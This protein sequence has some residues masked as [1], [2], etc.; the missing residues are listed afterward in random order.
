MKSIPSSFE[1]NGDQLKLARSAAGFSLADI[2]REIGVTRQYASRLESGATPST[3]QTKML[4]KLLSV[5]ESFFYGVRSNVLT[6]EQCHF[7]S[8]RSATKTLK[9]SITSQV[10]VLNS[11]II[12][13]LEEWIEFPDINIPD[14]EPDIEPFLSVEAVADE[15]RKIWNLGY[16]P[17][18]NMTKLLES[19]G[20]IV[21]NLADADERIDAF[22]VYTHR[23]LVVRNTHKLSPCRLRFDYAHELG[24]LVMHQGVETG[25]RLT[26][27]QAN[28][29]ASAFLMP[30]SSFYNDFPKLRGSYFN[31]EAL[32][33]LKVR[34]GV[35]LKA[36][37]Y[38]AKSLGLIDSEKAKSGYIYLSR[39]GYAKKE[40]GDDLVHPEAPT[41]LQKAFES[42]TPS[43][44]REII[45]SSSLSDE[46]ISE[47]FGLKLNNK[48]YLVPSSG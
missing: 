35:S 39:N 22:S 47:R 2:G 34:W 37:L 43:E 29:F 16:G 15:V 12:R 9:S 40:R 18:S 19:K 25:C 21:V 41:L 44:M 11:K 32:I 3:E 24:H 38:R 30:K 7:R 14:I 31:W 1:F 4:A 27:S 33:E 23:P 36:I 20:C 17:I 46:F 8:S 48:L 5:A 26:E 45:V 13:P 6:S 28:S 10:E 42:L